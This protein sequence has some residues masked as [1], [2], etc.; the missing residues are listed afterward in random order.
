MQQE[1]IRSA[2]AALGR[3][4][5]PGVLARVQALFAEEQ[6]LLAERRPASAADLAYGE[7]PR[8]RLDVY[9]PERAAGAPILVW[10]HG[11]GFMRG[12][13]GS[14]EHWPNANAGRMAAGAGFLGVVV[15]YRLAPEYGWPAGGEDVGA[16]VDW[17]KANAA[18]HGG[19]PDRIVLA[20]T[21]AGAVHVAT[22][23]QLR[24]QAGEVRGAVLLSGLYGITPFSDTRDFAYYGEDRSLHA[25]RAPL[26]AVTGTELPLLVACSEFD[27]PRFQAEFVGLL[28]RR[29]D[30]HGRLPPSH[31]GSGHN[32][33][34]LAYHLGTSDRRLEDEIV[35]FVREQCRGGRPG[36]GE[37][38]AVR[39]T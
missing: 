15:N 11:G 31:F 22:Y 14:T 32:H 28:Q 16:V 38:D 20:G 36:T 9:A 3:D 19:D 23:L 21:S 24:P 33:Y 1:R 34:S 25:A 7:H 18:R 10:V 26:E 30:R 6:M 8:Q 12:D 29:L 17:L 2:I 39:S 4:I 35:Q 13:K 5:D 27:P 37:E